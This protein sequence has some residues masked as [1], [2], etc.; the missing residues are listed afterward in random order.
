MNVVKRGTTAPSDAAIAK[1]VE[2]GRPLVATKVRLTKTADG[3]IRAA[4]P[5]A[6]P[7]AKS[8]VTVTTKTEPSA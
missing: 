3:L 1:L 8:N 5:K 6:A 4:T 7:K 2:L